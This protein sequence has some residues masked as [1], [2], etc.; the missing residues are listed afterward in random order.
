MTG[1]GTFPL[2]DRK[3]CSDSPSLDLVTGLSLNRSE[4][5][6]LTSHRRTH[7]RQARRKPN[8]VSGKV[9]ALPKS[10]PLR[11]KTP[12]AQDETPTSSTQQQAQQQAQQQPATSMTTLPEVGLD[13]MDTNR[14]DAQ[15]ITQRLVVS[16]RTPDGASIPLLVE[17]GYAADDPY[18][19]R[20]A[21]HP[22]DSPVRW[23]FA[24]DLL[25]SG[26]LEPVG[27]G[28]VHVW[29]CLDDEGVAVLSVELCSPYGD[30]LVEILLA[31]AADFVDRMHAVV[32]PGE[33][34]AR[35]DLDATIQAIYA[36]E[37]V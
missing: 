36:A 24:R 11:L 34:S 18:C 4:S 30:A 12:P 2:V 17:L 37:N 8:K 1:I 35:M 32:P 6:P 5:W 20:L 26:L 28:D 14:L 16:L 33:E 27:D 23:D 9:S 7:S 10:A 21:F 13:T 19:V 15:V 31:D 29:S 3:A 22:D 25:S